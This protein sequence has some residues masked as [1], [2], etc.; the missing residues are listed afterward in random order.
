M[1]RSCY[2]RR[3]LHGDVDPDSYLGR[4]IRSMDHAIW[5]RRPGVKDRLV[6]VEKDGGGVEVKTTHARDVAT[7][8][9]VQDNVVRVEDV[10]DGA[11]AFMID[12][13][14]VPDASCI[15]ARIDEAGLDRTGGALE[16]VW[17]PCPI[18]DEDCV[19]VQHGKM[20]VSM[21]IHD[22]G[23]ACSGTE[24]QQW[25]IDPEGYRVHPE[26]RAD[27]HVREPITQ[28]DGCAYRFV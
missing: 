2:D 9:P 17:T 3:I 7:P 13:T 6:G 5:F 16:S 20:C 21:Y 22:D 11:L 8:S 19:G 28:K 25:R 4:R 18:C 26:Q 1:C 27:A 23:T 12:H 10:S 14:N 24:I 15:E